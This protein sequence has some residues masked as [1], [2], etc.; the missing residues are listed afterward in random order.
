[1]EKKPRRLLRHLRIAGYYLGQ[2]VKVRL[3][4]RGDFLIECASSLFT[5]ACGLLVIGIIFASIPHLRNWS[6][7]EVFFI[8]GFAL[9]VQALFESVAESFYWFADKYI[10]RGEFDRVLLR[11]LNPLFQ[12]LLEN[13]SFE[14]VPDLVLGFAVLSLSG[15]SLGIPF[16]FQQALAILL[17]LLSAV[18]VL[19]GT[20][21]ALASVSF[22]VEDKVGVLPPFYNLT[23]FGR[24]PIT[25]YHTSLRL[26]LTWVLPYGFVAFYPAT[27]FLR[28]AEF[29]A[30][31]WATPAAG[32]L[33][34]LLGYTVFRAGIR[35]YRSTGS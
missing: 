20:F 19:T 26:L 1:M 8:Y 4:Y 24:Y 32:L 2:M 6:R 21:L 33:T 31:Y 25:I 35:R 14:S 11:P 7:E 29:A 9:T 18:L 17:M 22:W 10:M 15:A 13:F 12:I 30:Y 5:Q 3:Q 34:F 27:G 23:S 28:R 16:G